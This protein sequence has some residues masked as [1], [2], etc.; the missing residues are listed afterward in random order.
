MNQWDPYVP[1][2]NSYDDYE[3]RNDNV[4]MNIMPAAVPTMPQAPMMPTMMPMP[5]PPMDCGCSPMAFPMTMAPS[6]PYG[7]MPHGAIPYGAMPYGTMPYG[8]MPYGTMTPGMMPSSHW[9][10]R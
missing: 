10:Y 2:E 1:Q 9:P 3:W 5:T 4:P 6:M 7:T 8:T